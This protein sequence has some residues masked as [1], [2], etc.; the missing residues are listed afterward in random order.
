M[1]FAF[2]IIYLEQNLSQLKA[3]KA[4][5]CYEEQLSVLMNGSGNIGSLKDHTKL[6]MQFS[7]KLSA[8]SIFPCVEHHVFHQINLSLNFQ[9]YQAS[10]KNI[11]ILKLT[12]MVYYG[13]TL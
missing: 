5:K 4:T 3:I 6:K 13:S 12:L 7:S 10:N 2:N 1:F 9:F 11:S 8:I